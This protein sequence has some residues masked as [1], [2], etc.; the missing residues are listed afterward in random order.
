[1]LHLS[2][3]NLNKLKPAKQV[4]CEVIEKVYRTPATRNMERFSL[5]G[6][7]Y[8]LS[9]RYRGIYGIFN[10]RYFAKSYFEAWNPYN[11]KRLV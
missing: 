10:N 1:M 2:K 6:P 7:A 11:N 8:G 4:K 5:A 3:M 9:R